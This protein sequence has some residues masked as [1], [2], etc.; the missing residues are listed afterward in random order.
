[1]ADEDKSKEGEQKPEGNKGSEH[2][3]SVPYSKYVGVKEM[4]SKAE[5]KAKSLEEQLKNAPNAEEIAKTK[6]E[7]DRIK[8]EHK[9]ATE[10]LQAIKEKSVSEK[11]Q[12]L[13]AKGLPE[14]KLNEMSEKE[15]DAA[16]FAAGSIKGGANKLDL[17]GS[18]SGSTSLTG[19]PMD[20]A[21]MAYQ[22][23]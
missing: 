2:P 20:L 6:Q 3:E 1:M 19:S 18:G 4:L 17:G 15:L 16:L 23:K 5:E 21:K 11:R 13:K 9:K 14:E 8:E 7:L 10:E 12:S 22:N